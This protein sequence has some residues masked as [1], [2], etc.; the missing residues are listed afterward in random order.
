METETPKVKRTS[1]FSAVL[2]QLKVR[3]RSTHLPVRT[4]FAATGAAG[5][6]DVSTVVAAVLAGGSAPAGALLATAAAPS[7][8]L[9]PAVESVV[10][11]FAS[12]QATTNSVTNQ[13]KKWAVV[14]MMSPR[15]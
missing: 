15:A 13:R 4:L 12:L 6:L 9:G 5:A 3:F 7:P 10:A 14:R 8:A 1:D 2:Y 11:L